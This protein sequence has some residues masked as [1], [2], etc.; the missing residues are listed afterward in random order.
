MLMTTFSHAPVER[1]SDMGDPARASGRAETEKT[2]LDAAEAVFAELGFKGATTAEIARR[3][4]VPKANLHYY[5]ATKETLYRQILERVLD[6]WFLAAAAFEDSDEPVEALSRYIGAK[7]DMARSMP[8]ASKVFAT[9]IMRGAPIIQDRLETSLRAWVASRESIFRRW[10][11]QGR[12]APVEP[13]Y[14]LFM[15]WASTQHFADFHH[16]IVTLNGGK[17]LSQIQFE[18]AKQQ[19]IATILHGV[20]NPKPSHGDSR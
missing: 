6:A 2:I 5:F 3:A 13:R 11:A 10:I 9:E 16:Q 15:I 17:E 7:M 14:L 19:L 8:L 4:G 1:T 12:M 20:L 18:K